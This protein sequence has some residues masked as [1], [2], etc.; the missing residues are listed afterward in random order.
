M[1]ENRIVLRVAARSKL[2]FTSNL[3]FGGVS[4][5][6]SMADEFSEA[7]QHCNVV[8][9]GQRCNLNCLVTEAGFQRR[10]LIAFAGCQFLKRLRSSSG[11]REA[12][13]RPGGLARSRPSQCN[14]GAYG[15]AGSNH[16]AYPYHDS[17]NSALFGRRHRQT[18]GLGCS[19]SATPQSSRG[20]R[21]DR[22]LRRLQG[23]LRLVRC[24]RICCLRLRASI[25]HGLRL[26]TGWRVCRF[27]Q[28]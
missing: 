2:G 28:S 27:L 22:W 20:S 4:P 10:N 8:P 13:P 5:E 15:Y 21:P 6:S 12:S 11:T 1:R 18:C 26:G 17:A 25:W 9:E 14:H 24:L 3:L 16:R 19:H 7:R 23:A